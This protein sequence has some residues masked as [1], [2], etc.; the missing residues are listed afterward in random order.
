MGRGR[1][2]YY[3]TYRSVDLRPNH[4]VCV[5]YRTAFSRDCK[6]VV[7]V[8]TAKNS[9]NIPAVWHI[10]FNDDLD[11]TGSDPTYSFGSFGDQPQPVRL[12]DSLWDTLAVYRPSQRMYFVDANRDGTWSGCTSDRCI[13]FGAVAFANQ[14]VGRGSLQL[15]STAGGGNYIL[16][17]GNLTADD[18][19]ASLPMA[20]PDG[21]FPL[22][23]NNHPMIVLGRGES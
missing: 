4:S 2:G 20:V 1:S 15:W 12:I 13:G 22:M 7:G 23:S 17:N 3:R 14:A 21:G 11:L 9:P 19:D 16:D 10:N 5:C 6:T 18:G 8:F